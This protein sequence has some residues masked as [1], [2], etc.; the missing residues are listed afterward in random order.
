VWCEDNVKNFIVCGHGT[1][2]K[3]AANTYIRK[4]RNEKN[5]KFYIYIFEGSLTNYKAHDMMNLRYPLY[6]LRQ[7]EIVFVVLYVS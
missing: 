2:E 3:T 7:F 6:V 1:K 5:K 4:Y